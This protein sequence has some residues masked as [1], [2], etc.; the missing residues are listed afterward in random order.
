MR[1]TRTFNRSWALA[2]HILT[3]N[4]DF[5]PLNINFGLFKQDTSKLKGRRNRIKRYSFYTNSAKNEFIK[6]LENFQ[7]SSFMKAS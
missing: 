2:S 4:K 1:V 3:E 7:E 5:Q 6:W